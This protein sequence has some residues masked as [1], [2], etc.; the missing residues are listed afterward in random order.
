MKRGTITVVVLAALL[1]IVAGALTLARR[2]AGPSTPDTAATRQLRAAVVLYAVTVQPVRPP[3]LWSA[4]TLTAP[5]CAELLATY[6]QRFRTVVASGDQNAGL[7][8]AYLS[9]VL[10]QEREVARERGLPGGMVV[11]WSGR[12]VYWRCLRGDDH[13]AVVRAAVLLTERSGRWDRSL[14]RLKDLAARTYS[15]AAAD[16][17]TLRKVGGVWKVLRVKPWMWFDQ[18]EG[19]HPDSA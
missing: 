16:E 14:H 10:G 6:E 1:V 4:R 12:V 18:G 17:Y 2:S 11:G 9:E 19:V 5:R 13:E 7:G 15:S 3:V 8:G